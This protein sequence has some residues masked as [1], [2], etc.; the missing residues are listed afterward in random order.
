MGTNQQAQLP[1]GKRRRSTPFHLKLRH[2]LDFG[3][4]QA[5][6]LVAG[7]LGAILG[8]AVSCSTHIDRRIL[9][10]FKLQVSML[11]TLSLL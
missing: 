4:I 1:S 7:P 10:K 9:V 6:G 3:V 5:G 11:Q 2:L 8:K